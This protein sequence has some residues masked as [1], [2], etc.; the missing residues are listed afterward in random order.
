MLR[1]TRGPIRPL[2]DFNITQAQL[3]GQHSV[4]LLAQLRPS[5]RVLDACRVVLGGTEILRVEINLFD[6]VP[7]P[8]FADWKLR[9]QIWPRDIGIRRNLTTSAWIDLEA[10]IAGREVDLVDPQGALI[11]HG[12]FLNL[13]SN[14]EPPN[15][16]A[17]RWAVIISDN[18]EL[19]LQLQSLP[20]ASPVLNSKPALRK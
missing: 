2:A 14:S 5:G 15:T 6:V 13:L 16:G 7:N 11:P 8:T 4:E 9:Y 19:Q 20:A 1:F 18:G 17:C 10:L 12:E 3:A